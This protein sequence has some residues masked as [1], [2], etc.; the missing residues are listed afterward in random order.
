M[1]SISDSIRKL[2]EAMPAEV[3]ARWD[4]EDRRRVKLCE[5]LRVACADCLA[6]LAVAIRYPK[7]SRTDLESAHRALLR[8]MSISA[9]LDP[10]DV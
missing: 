8:A 5:D 4:E 9:V 1:D 3:R 6:D 7:I 10:E 2:R